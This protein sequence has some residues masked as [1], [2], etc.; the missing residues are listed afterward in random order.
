MKDA[1]AAIVAL[2]AFY[3]ACAGV[4]SVIAWLGR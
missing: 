3:A 2:V 1:I 4:Y